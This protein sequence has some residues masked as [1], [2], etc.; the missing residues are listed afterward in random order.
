MHWDWTP[1][2][3]AKLAVFLEARGL[4]RGDVT[5]QSIGDGHSN[6]T[7]LVCDGSRRVVVRRPPPPPT[8]PGA[9]DVLREAHLI[10]A[11]AGTA[12]PVPRLLATAQAGEVVDVPCYVMSFAAGPVVTAGTP[13]PL[14]SPALRRRIGH[15]LADTLANLHAV[16]WR[17]AGLAGFGRPEGFN[18]RHRRRV[19]GLVADDDG[20]PPPE[21]AEIDAW[22]AAHVPA[23]SG[24][25]VIHNDYRIGNVVLSADRPGEIAAVL[26]WELA[27]LGD[28]LLDVG[29]FLASVPE[30]GGRL[31]PTEELGVAMLEDGYPTRGELAD[32]YAERTGADL[33][34]LGWYTALALWKL[35]VLYE[36]GRRR[37]VRGA[38]DPYYANPALVPSFLEAA[39]RAAGLPPP[40]GHGREG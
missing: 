5:T 14:D 19:G 2:T 15:A 31:T 37:A 17:S 21:F 28:P 26:D 38:G 22:L 33:A 9:H 40:H 32:R 13:P 29:Y 27:T 12:V 24:A 7:F 36:Y 18:E 4:T 25:S 10:G 23:E 3:R 30:P 20:K 8:P 1:E 6:L 11:L 39:H 35:A 16:D 34:N